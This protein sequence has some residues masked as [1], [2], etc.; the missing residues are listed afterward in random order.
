MKGVFE[1]PFFVPTRHLFPLSR[2]PSKNRHQNQIKSF[3]MRQLFP[4]R[5]GESCVESIESL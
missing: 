3:E 2:S 1:P 5:T 4:R